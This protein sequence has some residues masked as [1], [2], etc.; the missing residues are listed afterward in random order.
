MGPGALELLEV[1]YETVLEKTQKDSQYELIKS[2]VEKETTDPIREIMTEENLSG[3]E[4]T[5]DS[6]RYYPYNNFAS[7]VIG[8]LPAPTATA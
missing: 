5:D 8:P 1:E 4:M 3:I 2:R 6:K 7:H